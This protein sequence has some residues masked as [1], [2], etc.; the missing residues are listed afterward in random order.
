MKGLE[1]YKHSESDGIVFG[2]NDGLLLYAFKLFLWMILFSQ[3]CL[4]Y[5]KLVP[6]LCNCPIEHGYFGQYMK[7]GELFVK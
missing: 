1:L 4:G 7:G 6:V 5:S 2:V 3:D